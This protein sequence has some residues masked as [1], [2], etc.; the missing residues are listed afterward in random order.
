MTIFPKLSI[1]KGKTNIGVLPGKHTVGH[2]FLLSPCKGKILNFSNP[3]LLRLNVNF[4]VLASGS[5]PGNMT[6]RRNNVGLESLGF[7]PCMAQ[8]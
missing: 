2:G 8:V 6:F 3:T 4:R 7:F 1:L 5:L